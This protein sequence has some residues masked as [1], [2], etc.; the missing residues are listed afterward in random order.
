MTRSFAPSGVKSPCPICGR[1]KDGD[2]RIASDSRVFCHT[3]RDGKLGKA[4]IDNPAYV[5]LGESSEG[6]GAG[7]WKL[8]ALPAKAPREHGIRYFDYCFWDGSP[9]PVQRFRKDVAEG[10]QVA[11]CKGGLDGRPQKDVAPYL[12]EKASAAKQLFVVRGELK[13]ELL[14]GKGFTAISL[15]NQKDEV[16]VAKLQAMQA[17][18]VE[19]V[20]VPDCDTADLDKW[21]KYLSSEVPG[22]KQLLAPGLP[23]ANPPADGGLGIEDWIYQSSPSNEQIL[24]AISST[25]AIDQ[26]VKD[27]NTLEN[28]ILSIK[29]TID[30]PLK[31]AILTRKEAT[32]L[33]FSLSEGAVKTLISQTGYEEPVLY[34]EEINAPAEPDPRLWGNLLLYQSS[35]LVIAKPKVGKTALMLHFAGCMLSGKSHCLGLPIYKRCDHLI[36]LGADMSVQQWTKLLRREG[37]AFANPDGTIS[38]PKVK[39]S[40]KGNGLNLSPMGIKS[41]VAMCIKRPNSLLFIDCLREYLAG[42][43]IDNEFIAQIK[44]LFIA[45]AQ[46]NCNVTIVC[47]HHARKAGGGTGVEASSGSNATTG[48]FDFVIN[49]EYLIP[50]CIMQKDKR[51]LISSIGRGLDQSL[52][53]ELQGAEPAQWVSHGN[54]EEVQKAEAISAA[55]EA[56]TVSQVKVWDQCQTLYLSGKGLGTRA[57]M[58]FMQ[59]S[60][61][62]AGRYLAAIHK[63]CLTV[64]AGQQASGFTYYPHYAERTVEG[65]ASSLPSADLGGR[66]DPKGATDPPS[67]LP[68]LGTPPS[69]TPAS[70]GFSSKSADLGTPPSI[71]PAISHF[72][73]NSASKTGVCGLSQKT[74]PS[75]PLKT[76]FSTGFE[77]PLDPLVSEGA[78]S[79]RACAVPKNDPDPL[80]SEGARRARHLNYLFS[81]SCFISEEEPKEVHSFLAGSSSNAPVLC[82]ETS[83]DAETLKP[84]LEQA[85]QVFR[86]GKWESGWTI[87]DSRDPHS[88]RIR[89]ERNGKA[90]QLANQRWGLDTRP[91]VST[92]LSKEVLG[93]VGSIPS[94]DDLG[95]ASRA[96]KMLPTAT[97]EEEFF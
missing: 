81:S 53:A 61:W 36:I 12:W 97:E 34:G 45:L 55:E 69:I 38:M 33:G 91:E 66:S 52:L 82:V 47:I 19:V 29:T 80:V 50:N 42:K 73:S 64:Q 83:N 14:C 35:N 59:C 40:A 86:Q 89:T 60:R 22:V 16:L 24:A 93:A 17:N 28:K 3:K 62:A 13:A 56:L 79:A 84:Q 76:E 92:S 6:Q 68:D 25:E 4:S 1:T 15:L 30:D 70:F 90:F 10:K 95:G 94:P 37:L 48:A 63:K 31:Q 21:F 49:M 8:D 75:P 7:M 9:C 65:S 39:L 2:C 32:G 71:S 58:E 77:N 78:R 27:L 54:A 88:L 85:V 11:W 41:I 67:Y 57:V 96:L 20:L 18:G 74:Q 44:P 46:A 23:W 5:Y 72:S 51:I 26:D 43:E 87:C